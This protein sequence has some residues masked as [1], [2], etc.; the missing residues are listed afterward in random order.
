MHP[1][2]G[3]A[4]TP[5][6]APQLAPYMHAHNPGYSGP[7]YGG[8]PGY[9]GH[10]GY[11]RPAPR[12]RRRTGS[13]IAAILV[14]IVAIAAWLV[15]SVLQPGLTTN[16]TGTTQQPIEEPPNPAAAG[17]LAEK[18][19]QAEPPT[20]TFPAE[21]QGQEPRDSGPIKKGQELK[22]GVP[23]LVLIESVLPG[24]VSGAGTG[25][26][27]T[28]DGYII[29]NYHVIQGST[30]IRVQDT[31][32][33]KRYEA[34]LVG[35]NALKDIAVLKLQ[36][37]K[38]LRTIA[39][40]STNVTLGS[41]VTVIGNGEAKGVL[42]Q[43]HGRVTDLNINIRTRA[44]GAVP[45]TRLD[46]LIATNADVV[47]GYSGG[48]MMQRGGH[49]IGMTVAASEGDSSAA[50]N[51]YAIPISTVV[52]ETQRILNGTNGD[53][54]IIGRP[55]AFGIT[56]ISDEKPNPRTP[57]IA[58][59]SFLEGS[60]LPKLGVKEGDRIT[61]INGEHIETYSDLKRALAPLRPG[62][63]VKIAWSANE[64]ANGGTGEGTVTLIRSGVN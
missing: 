60:P 46:N 49:V 55:A 41:R 35:H 40:P 9:A 14:V 58:I 50:V 23:G 63:K 30:A 17:N 2:F 56:V 11:G 7:A 22:D 47:Q 20:V 24:F 54:T 52:N 4:P 13:N 62:E 27:A 37:A 26:I 6:G 18:L 53:G 39:I 34:S 12:K 5:G 16:P 29:T 43:L 64:G 1:Y 25:L 15:P 3:N 19:R 8:Q 21:G 57:G 59:E 48:A 38:N 10:P 28:P 51:G 36:N 44:D 31:H 42:Q 61:M 33:K 32:T 45:G